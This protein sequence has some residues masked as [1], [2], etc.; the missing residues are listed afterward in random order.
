MAQ[1]RANP[2]KQAF[3]V[4]NEESNEGSGAFGPTMVVFEG[5]LFIPHI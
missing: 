4:P 1:V 2:I 3:R 5:V